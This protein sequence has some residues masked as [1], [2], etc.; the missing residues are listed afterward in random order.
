MPIFEADPVLSLTR[1]QGRKETQATQDETDAEDIYD[2]VNSLDLF[3]IERETFPD[4]KS[5]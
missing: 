3:Q 1:T 2:D 5:E 4:I